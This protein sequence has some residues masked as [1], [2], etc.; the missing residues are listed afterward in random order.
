M[1][2]ADWLFA[3]M[4]DA[5]PDACLVWPFSPA[6]GYCS[7]WFNGRTHRAHRLVCTWAHGDA[8]FA[9]AEAAH[10]C[11]EKRCVNPHHLRWATRVENEHDKFDHGTANVGQRHGM[12]KLTAR[13]VAEIRELRAA[14]HSR[15]DVSARFGI[16]PEYVTAITGHRIW[17]SVA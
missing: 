7:V 14:G 5:S 11:G 13:Q 12:A 17:K 16:G 9:D 4:P 10:S 1:S 2:R 15:A 6:Q 8:P 3:E